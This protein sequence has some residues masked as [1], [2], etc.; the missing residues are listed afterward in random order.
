MPIGIE[1]A[2]RHAI[3]GDIVIPRRHDGGNLRQPVQEGP[4]VPKLLLLR[5]LG[6]VARGDD[7]VGVDFFGEAKQRLSHLL[8][9]G[10]SEMDV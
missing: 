1:K 9:E 3:Q 2:L 8:M 4:R 6:E 10:R 7:H 5:P